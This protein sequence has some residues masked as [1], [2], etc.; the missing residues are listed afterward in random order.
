MLVWLANR[1]HHGKSKH[2]L[3]EQDLQTEKTPQ[4]NFRNMHTVGKGPTHH[5]PT[6]Y[7]RIS[8]SQRCIHKQLRAYSNLYVL[9]YVR[10][11][12]IYNA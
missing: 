12:L 7:V 3:V 11:Y 4:L 1:G 8:M 2:E 6:L 10:T 5:A 9:T